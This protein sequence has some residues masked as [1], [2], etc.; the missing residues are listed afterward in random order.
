MSLFNSFAFGLRHGDINRLDEKAE[1]LEKRLW[2]ERNRSDDLRL[3]LRELRRDVSRMLL[4]VETIQRVL[5]DRGIC[6]GEDFVK[7]MRAIDA[8][9]GVV[10]GRITHSAPEAEELRYCDG[11]QH[12]NPPRL[13]GCQ[14]CGRLFGRQGGTT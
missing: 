3:E 5:A 2:S 12:F 4:A 11:C 14:Y 8:E 6:S 7:R 10:D 9:D 1:V 13:N